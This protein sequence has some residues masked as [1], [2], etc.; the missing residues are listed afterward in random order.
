MFRQRP[1]ARPLQR[2][3]S[4]L[5][6]L[7]TGLVTPFHCVLGLQALLV[8]LCLIVSQTPTFVPSLSQLVCSSYCYSPS[9]A[10]KCNLFRRSPSCNCHSLFAVSQDCSMRPVTELM[11]TKSLDD[12]CS[13]QCSLHG[14][15]Q[16]GTCVCLPN[17]HGLDCSF[18]LCPG[19]G[20]PSFLVIG[21]HKGGTSSLSDYL[22]SH[23]SIHHV[24][25]LHFFDVEA[26][27]RRGL[28]WYLGHFRPRKGIYG[29][30][31]PKY[32]FMYDAPPDIAY[33]IGVHFKAIM[34]LRN[35][36]ERAWSAWNMNTYKRIHYDGWS[37]VPTFEETVARQ[38]RD[39]LTC[40]PNWRLCHTTGVLQRSGTLARG[41]Y[42]FQLQ[43]WLQFFPRKNLLV[44][45]SE[46]FF[47]NT[48]QTMKQVYH[49]L[50]LPGAPSRR[51]PVRNK[52]QDNPTMLA[53]TS[54]ELTVFYGP[55]NQQLYKILGTE[56]GWA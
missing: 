7:R 8:L 48:S 21:T 37:K 26:N 34:L 13:P 31:S 51:W 9:G 41:L 18:E 44:L 17:F 32:M 10:V 4:W 33:H 53:T 46:M 50:S 11:L 24:H 49:F 3:P 15:C 29:A 42:V 20:L 55:Y 14:Q 47:K 6:C 5:C 35:P 30:G 54:Q 2:S 52:Y 36:A 40:L 1:L 45:S 56:F 39:L 19:C 23:P 16:N 38:K 27:R 25:K 43:R 22:S 12:G 28:S